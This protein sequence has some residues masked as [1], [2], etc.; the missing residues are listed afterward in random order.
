MSKNQNQILSVCLSETL[1]IEND[2]WFSAV[3]QYWKQIITKQAV[4]RHGSVSLSLFS[5]VL[6]TNFDRLTS[7]QVHEWTMRNL[8]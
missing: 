6:N 4:R 1:S 2:L 5:E 8:Q 7:S 3:A